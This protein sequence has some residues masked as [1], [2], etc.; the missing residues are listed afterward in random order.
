MSRGIQAQATEAL[1]NSLHDSIPEWLHNAFKP[2]ADLLPATVAVSLALAFALGC[3]VASIYRLT[4]GKPRGQS[5]G[6]LAS[7]VLLTVLICAVTQ[8]IGNNVARAFSLA[9]V[10]AIVRFRTVVEDTRDTGFVIFA[11]AVGM[12]VGAGYPTVALIGIP[13][14]ALAAFIFRPAG[15]A[16]PPGRRDFTLTVRVG[17]GYSP[18]DLLRTPFAK[19]L[20]QVRLVA[21]MTARQGAAVD[22]T[23]SVRLRQENETI[24]LVTELNVLEGV[25]N[26]E[27]RQ[28]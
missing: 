7:F 9:G 10:L 19:H 28:A 25:Q 5:V 15:A 23:Y 20:E 1:H 4:Y 27:M 18:D 17:A 24:P 13:F 3:V 6:L 8:V 22:I 26:V 11:V 12:A 14:A 2:D 16:E 21:A